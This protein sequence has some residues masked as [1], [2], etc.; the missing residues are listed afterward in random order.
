MK[1]IN[2]SKLINFQFP[3]KVISFRKDIFLYIDTASEIKAEHLSVS[4]K[5]LDFEWLYLNFLYLI[6]CV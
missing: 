3:L 2:E 5:R 6:G 4:S 1:N